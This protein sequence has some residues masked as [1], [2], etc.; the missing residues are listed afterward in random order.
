MN[1]RERKRWREEVLIFAA[2][3]RGCQFGAD[4]SK[5]TGLRYGRVVASLHSMVEEGTVGSS[6]TVPTNGRPARRRYWRRYIG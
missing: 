6:F 1:R 4:I 5:L 2:L 3:D